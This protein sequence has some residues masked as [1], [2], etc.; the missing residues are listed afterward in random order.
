MIQG[1]LS[2]KIYKRFPNGENC[3]ILQVGANDG[4]RHDPLYSIITES[5]CRAFL[6]EP[7]DYL[8]NALKSLHHHN[9]RVCCINAAVSD[10]SETT[11]MYIVDPQK[12]SDWQHGIASLD[13][14]FHKISNTDSSTII[15][16]NVSTFT[17]QDLLQTFDI[18]EVDILATDCEGYDLQILKMFPFCKLKPKI[19]ISELDSR[20]VF[21]PKE[22]GEFIEILTSNGY[23]D[24][25]T[26]GDDIVAWM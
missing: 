2:E 13:S 6:I 18:R 26:F 16:K 3:T 15:P 17:F 21:S 14:D 24:F 25:Q 10:K 11:V 4:Y 12:A 8:Y 22:C 1:F 9:D 20:N 23:H 19:I 7:I 5:K